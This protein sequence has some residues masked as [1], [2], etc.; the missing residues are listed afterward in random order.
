MAG[1]LVRNS[2]VFFQCDIQER[3]RDL[4]FNMPSVIYVGQQMARFSKVLKVPLVVT[5][6][7]PQA[8]GHTMPEVKEHWPER[9]HYFGEKN[10]FTMCS[11]DVMKSMSEFQS[12]VLYGIETH[13]CVQQTCLDL[14][15]AGFQ[16]HLLADGIS[17]QRAI[18]RS[19]GLVRMQQAGAFLTSFESVVFELMRSTE[20]PSF[21][22]ANKLLKIKPSSP[23]T[24]L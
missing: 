8:L 2:T 22:E 19:A 17:S 7:Y 14:L 11:E 24:H 21:R 4:I 20:D 1:R 18:D 9:L 3:F 13:V 12:V 16:V 15:A 23:F 6:Q 5:E 10:T